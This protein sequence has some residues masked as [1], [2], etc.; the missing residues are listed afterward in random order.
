MLS[1]T[2]KE[3][4]NKE[5]LDLYVIGNIVLLALDTKLSL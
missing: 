1:S 2:S 3:D 4:T 5:R